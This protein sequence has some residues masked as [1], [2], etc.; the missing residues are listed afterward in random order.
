[1]FDDCILHMKRVSWVFVWNFWIDIINKLYRCF[2]RIIYINY[3]FHYIYAHTHTHLRNVITE[4]ATQKNNR[5]N[6]WLE[7]DSFNPSPTTILMTHFIWKPKEKNLSNIIKKKN[8]SSSSDEN[9]NYLLFSGFKSVTVTIISYYS[10][11]IRI[12][13]TK[14]DSNFRPLFP[15]FTF[16]VSADCGIMY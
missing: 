10:I 7:T 4:K 14:K 16:L 2:E 11:T 9:K 13:P 1:M 3:E 6:L 12:R 15:I 5:Y 8:T